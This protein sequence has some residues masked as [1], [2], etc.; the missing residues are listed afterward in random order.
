MN[1]L[2]LP[3]FYNN[4]KFYNDLIRFLKNNPQAK[5]FDFSIESFHGSY[6]YNSWNGDINSNYG[7]LALNKDFYLCPDMSAKVLRYDFSNVFLTQQDFYDI[8]SNTIVQESSNGSCQ[9]E[10]SNFNLLNY[11]QEK[12]NNYNYIFSGKSDLINPLN[13]DIINL[14]NEQDL[15]LFI[16]LPAY[17]KDEIEI[18]N[19]IK[20]KN[21]IE[22]TICG[23]CSCST[24]I[25]KNCYLTEQKNQIE[26]SGKSIYQNCNKINL[27]NNY[28]Q[29]KKE[30]EDFNKL[31]ITHFKI[32]SPPIGLM[33]TFNLFLIN[34]LI[35]EEYVINFLS[36]TI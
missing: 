11:L 26:F 21:K 25:Q 2:S 13:S 22:I 36:K 14:I 6:S 30:V 3:L 23:R 7:E 35:K 31:G 19:K 10:L 9:I 15:F 27:Y 5:K 20:R 16:N 1:I 34:S 32:E 28:N 4:F 24:Q 12:Y 8:H 33:K 17:Y 18:I 29:I